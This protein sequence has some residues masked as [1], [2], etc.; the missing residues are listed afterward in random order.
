M[1][2]KLYLIFP[3]LCLLSY[4]FQLKAAEVKNLD[5]ALIPVKDRSKTNRRD[6][7]KLCLKEVI[8][9]NSGTYEALN[10]SEIKKYIQKPTSV[11]VQYGYQKEARELVLKCRFDLARI[12]AVLKEQKLPV[13]GAQRPL[14]MMWLATPIQ[15]Q[16]TVIA[17]SDRSQVRQ[18]LQHES[19]KRGLPFVMPIMDLKDIKQINI[20]DIRENFI[21]GLSKASIRYRSDFFAV[22]YIKKQD[23]A[24]SYQVNLY[25]KKA[26]RSGL[27]DAV[28]RHSG[29]AKS[30]KAAVMT[31]IEQ[32][33][34]YY[35]DRYATFENMDQ[36][37]TLVQF[38]NIKSMKGLWAL[39]AYLTKLNI[40]KSFS[41]IRFQN[42]TA[43]FELSLRG[44]DDELKRSLRL[45]P[46]VSKLRGYASFERESSEQ[47]LMQIE[48]PMYTFK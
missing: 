34:I 36:V 40:V 14:T 12:H 10:N 7:L 25:T 20:N 11:L 19:V 42:Y 5:Q 28:M 31:I 16:D 21:Q 26:I 47:E 4:T 30:Q 6:A 17:D 13:W 35:A 1:K 22:S 41:L 48:I 8:L 2:V 43:L 3:L 15:K 9:K 23:R 44:S 29:V 18:V 39:E 24:W 27:S 32:L 46:R 37:A 33:N 45:E 38:N